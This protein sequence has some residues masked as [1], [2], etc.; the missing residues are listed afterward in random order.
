MTKKDLVDKIKDLFIVREDDGSYNLFGQYTVIQ[1]AQG[2]YKVISVESQTEFANL[3]YAVT[4]CVFDKNN[5]HKEI[6]RLKELDTLISGIDVDIAI[7]ERLVRKATD[8]IDKSIYTAKL[9][10]EKRKKRQFLKEIDSFIDLSKW[11][12]GKKYR[13]NGS[14]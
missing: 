12:Q 13:E 10:E 9:I 3:K 4:W 14:N 5:K 8:E 1:D 2:H 6:K 11:I 7:H